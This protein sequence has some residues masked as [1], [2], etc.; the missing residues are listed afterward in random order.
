MIEGWGFLRE[1]SLQRLKN[2]YIFFFLIK[3]Y[4]LIWRHYPCK[5]ICGSPGVTSKTIG[6][7]VGVRHGFNLEK[8][9]TNISEIIFWSLINI[10]THTQICIIYWA[11]KFRVG[12][13]DLI[14][15]TVMYY[16]IT[17]NIIINI[18]IFKCNM[19]VISLQK[20]F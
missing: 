12:K 7:P 16:I 11:Q 14:R 9:S 18:Y 4:S 6:G 10:N 2:I 19:F 3:R 20:S 17:I 1:E 15:N 5:N 13:T 8:A